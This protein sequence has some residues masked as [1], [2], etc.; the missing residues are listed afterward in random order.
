MKRLVVGVDPGLRA[1]GVGAVELYSKK[2]VKGWLVVSP[3]QKGD[4]GDAFLA[5]ARQVV[6]EISLLVAAEEAAI[7]TLAVERQIIR[8]PGPDKANPKKTRTRNPQQIVELGHVAAM[9]L[10]GVRGANNRLFVWPM[11]WNG[12]KRK[13]MADG[14]VWRRLEPEEK[15]RLHD[16]EFKQWDEDGGAVFV[17]RGNNVVDSVGIAKWAAWQSRLSEARIAPEEQGERDEA[18]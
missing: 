4:G 2:L 18:R 14:Q 5:M 7:E 9:I 16:C 1:C 8:T 12:N 3:N 11:S 15:E 6:L 10:F 13:A 17:G